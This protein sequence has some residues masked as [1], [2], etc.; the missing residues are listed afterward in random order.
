VPH[1]Q[2]LFGFAVPG[3]RRNH[4]LLIRQLGREAQEYPARTVAVMS[5]HHG[6]M[7]VDAR[8][9]AQKNLMVVRIVAG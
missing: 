9:T 1:D 6:C 8:Q 7:L 3:N 5:S 4:E 2:R